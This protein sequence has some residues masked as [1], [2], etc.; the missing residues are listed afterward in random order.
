MK[1][2][3]DWSEEQ[4]QIL[5]PDG[6]QAGLRGYFEKGIAPGHFLR[7]VLENDLFN[8]M[9]RADEFNRLALPNYVRFIYNYAPGNSYGSP[10]KVSA[11]LA[12]FRRVEEGDA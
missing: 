11:W 6:S 1:H 10:E 5:I 12:K 8:A 2:L 9:G 3:P 7:A 4:F